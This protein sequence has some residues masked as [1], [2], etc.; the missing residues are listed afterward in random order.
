[1]IS[2]SGWVIDEVR[3]VLKAEAIT[4]KRAASHFSG[5]AGKKMGIW[6]D[7]ARNGS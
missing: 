1:M 7:F 3:K 5:P 4:D 2:S 6:L